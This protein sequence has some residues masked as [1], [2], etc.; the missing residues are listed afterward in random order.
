MKEIVDPIHTCLVVW[1]VQNALVERI[2]NKEEFVN[3]LETLIKGVRGKMP[4]FYTKIT[5][6]KNGFQSSW[7]Y[8]TTMKN[9]GISPEE[10]VKMPHFMSK[11]E[12]R[13]VY[14]EVFPSSDDIVIEKSTASIFVGTDFEQMLRN[15]GIT[16][17]MFTGI[18]TEIGIESSA[19][20]ASNRGFYT[21]IISDCVSSSNKELHESA[22]KVLDK[23]FIVR[24]SSEILK[25]I[26][27]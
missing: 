26:P 16:T 2:F 18:S 13:D 15:R 1:D 24:N 5:P 3:H 8:Y 4:I 9:F 21:V 14:P 22:L 12:A 10:A 17:I 27:N 6:L 7:S 20:D 23:M 11:P 19:R 25:S